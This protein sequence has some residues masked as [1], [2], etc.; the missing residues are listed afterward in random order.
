MVKKP[1]IRKT[2]VGFKG[3]DKEKLNAVSVERENKR[4]DFI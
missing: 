3:I 4:K 1:T 2:I